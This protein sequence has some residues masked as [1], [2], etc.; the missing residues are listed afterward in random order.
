MKKLTSLI[1]V[2]MMLLAAVPV[3]AWT[4]EPEETEE[5]YLAGMVINATVGEYN[6]ADG[7]FTVTL[8]ADD[9]FD[10]EDVEKLAAGD[11]FLAGG[12]VYTVREKSEDEYGDLVVVTESGEEIEFVQIGDDHMSAQ[13]QEDGRRC[14]HAFAVL[15][16]PVAD[17]IIYED[18][19][20]PERDAAEV[21]Y[22]LEDILKIKAEKE[23]T[24]I[25]FDFYSTVI[26]INAKLE[27]VRI[28]Q[29]YDPAQ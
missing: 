8:Y 3:L 16:L 21:A 11:V 7:T 18:N 23:E 6:A 24:S 25:G 20:D 14:M 17:V 27:I 2:V 22:G 15:R 1:L 29:D 12:D 10:V 4:M 28:H 9:S 5:E 13:F 26:E 19:S